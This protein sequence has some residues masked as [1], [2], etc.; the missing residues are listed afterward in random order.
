MSRRRDD[1]PVIWVGWLDARENISL[2][3]ADTVVF[4]ADFIAYLVE[5]MRVVR[6]GGVVYIFS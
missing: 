4:Q 1:R 2:F 3:G 6:D 5:Q